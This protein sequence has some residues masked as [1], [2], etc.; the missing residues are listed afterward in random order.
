[1]NQTFNNQSLTTTGGFNG[2]TKLKSIIRNTQDNFSQ[3]DKRSHRDDHRKSI[4][5]T[6]MEIEN[7]NILINDNTVHEKPME[8]ESPKKEPEINADQT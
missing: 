4:E 3:L 7:Q 8:E 2:R 5:S 1:M 6:I